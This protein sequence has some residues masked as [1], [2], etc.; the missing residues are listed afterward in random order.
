MLAVF[1]EFRK[2]IRVSLANTPGS[3][4]PRKEKS[5]SPPI[6]KGTSSGSKQRRDGSLQFS[7]ETSQNLSQQNCSMKSWTLGPGEIT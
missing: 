1:A 2:G 7:Q 3:V 6:N 4:F 5:I